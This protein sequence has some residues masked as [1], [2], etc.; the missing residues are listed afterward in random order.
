[1]QKKRT[2]KFWLVVALIICLISSV[3]ASIVQSGGGKIRI[4][5]INFSTPSGHELSA[6]FYVFR[7]RLR[8]K[9]QRRQSCVP[10]DGTI[11]S[12]CRI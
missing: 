2:S 1:M 9:T 8:R 10:M 6:H 4:S 12:R 5:T 3:G 11:T 7:K